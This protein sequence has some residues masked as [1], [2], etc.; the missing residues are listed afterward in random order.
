MRNWSSGKV[1]ARSFVLSE[2]C[3]LQD[4]IAGQGSGGSMSQRKRVLQKF[5]DLRFCLQLFRTIRAFDAFRHLIA[6]QSGPKSVVRG[7]NVFYLQSKS[8]YSLVIAALDVKRLG[9]K[10]KLIFRHCLSRFYKLFFNGADLAVNHAGEG[11]GGLRRSLRM[12]GRS[13]RF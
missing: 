5:H 6:C 2:G 13:G 3:E 4:I 1:E 11:W 7:G 10:V 8:T 9:G 12:W